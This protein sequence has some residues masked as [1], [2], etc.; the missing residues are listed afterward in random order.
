M[1]QTKIKVCSTDDLSAVYIVRKGRGVR[2]YGRGPAASLSSLDN[3]AKSISNNVVHN[4]L[5][6]VAHNF[7][8]SQVINNANTILEFFLG[9]L[10]LAFG[11]F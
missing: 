8:S 11:S 4:Y 2:S 1:E 10:F 6:P 5:G 7:C 9:S 3:W